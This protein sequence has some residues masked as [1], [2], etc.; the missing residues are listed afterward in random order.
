MMFFFFCFMFLLLYV[1]LL[2]VCLLQVVYAV[3]LDSSIVFLMY[4]LSAVCIILCMFCLM[5]SLAMYD[6]GKLRSPYFLFFFASCFCL[7][8]VRFSVTF[9]VLSLL[10]GWNY[11][12]AR[13]CRPKK[14]FSYN[15][16]HAVVEKIL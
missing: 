9:F 5:Y 14:K 7:A 16:K 10:Q 1:C 11:Y 15:Q 4:D 6:F 8:D 13:S 12:T 2:Y 3:C